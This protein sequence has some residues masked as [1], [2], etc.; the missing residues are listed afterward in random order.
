MIRTDTQS[1][2]RS[3]DRGAVVTRLRSSKAARATLVTLLATLVL[4]AFLSPLLLATATALSSSEQIASLNAPPWPADAATFVY[5]GDEYDIYKVPTDTGTHEWALVE[6]G[7]QESGFIDP[8]NPEAGIITWEGSWR[9]LDRIWSFAP[10][11]SNFSEVWGL[12]NFP[13]TLFNTVAITV[14]ST[15][16]TLLSATL[17]AYGFARFRF[18]AKKIL[19]TMLVATIF[20]PVAATIIPTYTLFLK[21]GWVG[22][23]LPIIVPR[24]FGNAYD[25]FLL[26]QYFMTIPRQLDEAA[27][28]DGAGPIRTL[29]SVILPQAIPAITAV[30]IFHAVFAWNDF[31]TPLIYLST[32][33]ELQPLTV[34]LAR[35][36]GIHSSDPSFI[37]AGTLLTVAIP[38]LF[39]FFFQRV[40]VR[41]VV[42]SGV[43]K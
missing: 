3:T 41:G 23:W 40:F 9:S 8:D 29:R 11:W 43:E 14:L 19:F 6:P 15:I 10:R 26:R 17:V 39:F 33:P 18:P 12:L 34:A 32:S 35:F 21:L 30:A 2:A 25:V 36:K 24:F 28:I 5:Q 27:M 20:L 31:F 16:G 1:S 22:T 42:F 4:F 37:Q 38:V 7:R 13:R